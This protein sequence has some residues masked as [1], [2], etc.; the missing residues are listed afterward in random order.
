MLGLDTLSLQSTTRK[1]LGPRAGAE[2]GVEQ[3]RAPAGQRERQAVQRGRRGGAR[4][5]GRGQQRRQR[6]QQ[7]DRHAVV[8]RLP[9]A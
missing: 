7:L 9:H 5:R 2:A 3:A 6:A 1:H 8:P 4:W